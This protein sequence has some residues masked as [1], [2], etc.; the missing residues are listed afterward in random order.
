VKQ[1]DRRP[2]WFQLV[3]DAGVVE[4][5]TTVFPSSNGLAVISWRAAIETKSVKLRVIRI[6]EGCHLTA[7]LQEIGSV[8]KKE[9][10]P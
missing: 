3:A 10:R 1:L 2:G 5:H 7:P 6:A 9:D 8:E 4:M